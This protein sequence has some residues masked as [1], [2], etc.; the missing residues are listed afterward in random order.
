ME[1]Q[2]FSELCVGQ[3]EQPLNRFDNARGIGDDRATRNESTTS[4]AKERCRLDIEPCL[5]DASAMC[6]HQV[7]NT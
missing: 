3:F 5:G 2:R 4:S 1:R 6:C 7:C